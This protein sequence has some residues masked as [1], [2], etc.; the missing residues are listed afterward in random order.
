M[1]KLKT[2]KIGLLTIL[3][4]LLLA[5]SA[6]AQWHNLLTLDVSPAGSSHYFFVGPSGDL[7]SDGFDDF[8]VGDPQYNMG[9][10][11]LKII[12]GSEN[13]DTVAGWIAQIPHAHP[14]YFGAW[15]DVIGDM[16]GDGHDE[17]VVGA[18]LYST[19]FGRVFLYR[20]E[21][22]DT[23][24]DEVFSGDYEGFGYSYASGDIDAD[25]YMD[26]LVG[27]YPMPPLSQTAGAY[28]FLGS[29]EIDTEP[30]WMLFRHEDGEISG[31]SMEPS[32]SG[33]FDGD[34]Y[35]DFIIKERVIYNQDSIVTV[36]HL[37]FGDTYLDSI[38]DY[39]I[40]DGNVKWA[41]DLNNDNMV[42]FIKSRYTEDSYW[43]KLYYG[44]IAGDTLHSQ[45]LYDAVFEPGDIRYFLK[46]FEDFNGDNFDDL[47]ILRGPIQDMQYTF[48]AEL[49]FGSTEID[50]I[51]DLYFDI[52]YIYREGLIDI[53]DIDGNG[54]REVVAQQYFSFDSVV[55]SIFTDGLTEIDT[56]MN[57]LNESSIYISAYPNPF[58]GSTTITITY[59][60]LEGGEIEIYN[61]S[62]QLIKRIN[63]TA[64]EG[65]IM[66]DARDALG[67]KVSSGIYFARARAGEYVTS[68]KLLYLK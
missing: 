51:P 50:T 4:A 17:I 36:F 48:T 12:Y 28:L 43:L 16:D 67:D 27:E 1:R 26:L 32:C 40:S 58:N 56:E 13:P 59:N 49:L 19:Y 34:G 24:Y 5:A 29:P 61:I 15:A 60:D 42:D 55:T 33:D 54:G 9:Q 2:H 35:D 46:P 52:P 25:G 30:D 20:T 23:L 21:P 6:S 7:N 66:W 37:Y 44:N 62:G 39:S 68:I 31:L 64:M 63:T 3:S 47:L 10:G 11:Y 65:K 14:S 45:L 57:E 41:G 38:P 18:P 8:F 53:G 22:F